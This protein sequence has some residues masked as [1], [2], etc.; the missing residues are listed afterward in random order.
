MKPCPSDAPA[1]APL[2]DPQPHPSEAA[3]APTPAPA[4]AVPVH[5]AELVPETCPHGLPLEGV[6]E[7]RRCLPGGY[8]VADFTAAFPEGAELPEIAAVLETSKQGVQQAERRAIRKLLPLLARRLPELAAAMPR[9][10]RLSDW[11]RFAAIVRRM[12]REGF[13]LADIAENLSEPAWRVR[14]ASRAEER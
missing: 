3:G 11:E 10:R 9:G 7:C 4:E 5:P 2:P 12:L 1:L 8:R 14:R 13:E 6:E